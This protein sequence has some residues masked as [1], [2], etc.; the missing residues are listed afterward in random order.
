MSDIALQADDFVNKAF[1]LAGNAHEIGANELIIWG[2]DFE[3]DLLPVFLEAWDNAP[4]FSWAMIEEVSRFHVEETTTPGQILPE[5]P[6]L[7]ERLRCF[8]PTGDLDIRRDGDRCY[9]HFI[10]ETNAGWDAL[11]LAQF[12]MGDFWQDAG[13]L[14]KFREI[15]QSY[16]QWLRGKPEQRVKHDWV[17][18]DVPEKRFNYLQQKQY[19]DNGRIAFVRYLDFTEE[20]ANE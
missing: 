13:P 17:A 2:G 19:L 16:F 3:A 4:H 7:V 5:Q 14:L 1:R 15:S 20:A 18:K 9:W 11:D 10:G 8:G 6:Y 12:N